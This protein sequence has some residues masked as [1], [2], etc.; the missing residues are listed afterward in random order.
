MK[1]TTGNHLVKEEE[2]AATFFWV[3]GGGGLPDFFLSRE[4]RGLHDTKKFFLCLF[5]LKVKGKKKLT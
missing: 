2:E 5:M 1:T 4:H 3:G